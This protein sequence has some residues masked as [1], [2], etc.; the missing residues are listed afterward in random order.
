MKFQD[1]FTHCSTLAPWML[2]PEKHE[3][4]IVEFVVPVG[5]TKPPD[6]LGILQIDERMEDVDTR[7]DASLVEFITVIETDDVAFMGVIS[8][9][10]ETLFSKV[11]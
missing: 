6:I 11:L 5:T 2:K 7:V 3:M 9:V 8:D 10:G 4:I 1:P